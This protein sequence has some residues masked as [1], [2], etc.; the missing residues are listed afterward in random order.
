MK[1]IFIVTICL[2]LGACAI[3]VR[4]P[5]PKAPPK[6]IPLKRSDNLKKC[7]ADFLDKDVTPGSAIDICERIYRQRG[8]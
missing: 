5:I 8:R 3:P 2:L 6:S 7:V 1:N 4:R